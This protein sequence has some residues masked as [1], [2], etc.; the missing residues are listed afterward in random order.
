MSGHSS[1]SSAFHVYVSL[2]SG[3]KR[4]LNIRRRGHPLVLG[5]EGCVFILI[6]VTDKVLF[7]PSFASRELPGKR[8]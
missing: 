4:H 5:F 8:N 6:F 3:P 7:D 1:S 2:F